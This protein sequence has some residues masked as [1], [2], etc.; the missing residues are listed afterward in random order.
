M[1]GTFQ[2][3]DLEDSNIPLIYS[4]YEQ[5]TNSQLS[6][7]TEFLT[8]ERVTNE[9]FEQRMMELLQRIT[10]NQQEDSSNDNKANSSG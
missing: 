3:T 7:D 4:R 9:E 6:P 5:T 8:K 2:N 10:L 1:F